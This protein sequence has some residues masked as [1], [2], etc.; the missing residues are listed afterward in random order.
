MNKEREKCRTG[1]NNTFLKE[2]EMYLIV[3]DS[4]LIEGHLRSLK[5]GRG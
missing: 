2:S 3:R 5:N 1:D 4:F